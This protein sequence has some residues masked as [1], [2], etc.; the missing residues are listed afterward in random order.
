M[1]HSG[2]TFFGIQAAARAPQ[3]YHAYIG[4]SQMVNQL[5]SERRAYAYM[6]Q[7]FSE[8][9]DAGMVALRG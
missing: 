8:N 5:E 3:L 9:G 4:V 2:G 7:R 6:L 1:R